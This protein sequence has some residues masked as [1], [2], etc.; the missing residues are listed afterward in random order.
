VPAGAE[1]RVDENLARAGLEPVKNLLGHHGAM[2][3]FTHEIKEL[4]SYRHASIAELYPDSDVSGSQY[5]S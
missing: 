1:S 2:D 3:E 5:L 4:P